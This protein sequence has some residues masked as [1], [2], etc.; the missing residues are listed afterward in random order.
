LARC[1]AELIADSATPAPD[2]TKVSSSM[3]E[4]LEDKE[5]PPDSYQISE[6]VTSPDTSTDWALVE[7]TRLGLKQNGYRRA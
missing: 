3:I 2:R 5:R 4:L 6:C 7:D 1:A